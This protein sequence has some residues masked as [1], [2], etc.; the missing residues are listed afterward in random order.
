MPDTVESGKVYAYWYNG[1][2]QSEGDELEQNTTDV[3]IG[4]LQINRVQRTL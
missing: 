1:K 2:H 4:M 3:V